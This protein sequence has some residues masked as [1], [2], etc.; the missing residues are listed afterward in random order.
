[1]FLFVAVPL[2]DPKNTIDCIGTRSAEKKHERDLVSKLPLEGIRDHASFTM[3]LYFLWPSGFYFFFATQGKKWWNY[4]YFSYFTSD[5]YA[6][7]ST[8]NYTQKREENQHLHWLKSCGCKN[9]LAVKRRKAQQ[10][11]TCGLTH[12]DCRLSD[13]MR[14]ERSASGLTLGIAQPNAQKLIPTSAFDDQGRHYW[15]GE[16]KKLKYIETSLSSDYRR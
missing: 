7:F 8:S 16:K 3:C 5:Y 4:N 14:L 15:K 6:L 11:K 13:L 12:L 9:A 1:M 2:L 10:K